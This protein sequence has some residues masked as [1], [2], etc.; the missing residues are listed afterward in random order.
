MLCLLQSTNKPKLTPEEARQKADELVRAAREKREKE[1]KEDAVKKEKVRR[2]AMQPVHIIACG[3]KSQA[4]SIYHQLLRQF[5]N[6]RSSGSRTK[7]PMY[8]KC[9][10]SKTQQPMYIISYVLSATAGLGTINYVL[11]FAPLASGG[12]RGSLPTVGAHPMLCCQR[13]L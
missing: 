3:S 2:R 4:W 5:Y 12:L 8:F 6:E 10:V 9:C 1:E 13:S 7:H 11:L